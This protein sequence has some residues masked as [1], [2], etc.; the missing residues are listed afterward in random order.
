[1][2]MENDA[3]FF[4]RLRD[5]DIDSFERFYKKYHPRAYLFCRGLLRDDDKA[6]DIVQECFILL[7]EHRTRISS[8]E[9]VISYFFTT[10]KHLCLK[11]IRRDMFC[12]SFSDM[13]DVALQELELTYRTSETNVLNDIY[14]N[15][16][17]ERYRDAL[18]KL[19]KQC[20]CIFKMSHDEG[21]KS[22]E[23]ASSLN[24]SVRTVENQLYRGLK[25]IKKLMLTCLF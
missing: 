22:E 14:F 25:L 2:K 6:K 11:Q 4:L 7:W 23:I 16:L 19:P 13:S 3:D 24:L 21:M 10:L 20:Q 1:M 9:A 18:Q 17:S 5:G 15:D 12:H 8:R